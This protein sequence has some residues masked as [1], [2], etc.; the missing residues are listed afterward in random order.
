MKP[1]TRLK[2][3]SRFARFPY[4]LVLKSLFAG[5]LIFTGMQTPLQAQEPQMVKYAQPSL[6]LQVELI[7]ISTVVPHSN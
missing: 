3:G 6:A 4:S 1:N 2:K 7:L 5:A